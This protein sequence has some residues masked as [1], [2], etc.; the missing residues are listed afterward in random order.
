MP[1]LTL[2]KK[3]LLILAAALPAFLTVY[4]T[5]QHAGELFSRVTFLGDD[6][7]SRLAY[8]AHWLL[9]PGLTLLGGI[10]ATSGWRAGLA[11]AIDGTQTP[12][13]R[14]LE[15]TLRYNQNT[16]EQ[17]LLAAIAWAGVGLTA[18]RAH[19]VVIPAMACPFAL[20][21]IAFWAGYILHPQARAFGMVLTALPTVVAYGWLVAKIWRAHGP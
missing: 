4:G 8:V 1:G 10:V 16:L 15:I 19:L 20:G 13:N 12:E 3:Q 2:T 7:A 6:P 11:G 14:S 5:W 9:L 18:A 17:L 21:R